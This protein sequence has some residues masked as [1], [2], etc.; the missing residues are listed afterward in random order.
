MKKGL[1]EI[2]FIADGMLGKLSRWLRILGYDVKYMENESDNKLIEL[3]EK[4][5]RILL[6]SDLQL[7]TKALKSG[8]EAFLVD[9]KNDAANLAKISEKFNLRLELD[10]QTSR[11][12]ICNSPLRMIPPS[13]VE[14]KVPY[15]TLRTYEEFWSCTNV[16]CQ[17]IYWQGSHWKNIKEKL[18]EAK[19]YSG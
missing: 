12:P 14:G 3:A 16:D 13:E 5:R 18:K 1:G 8:V 15:S 19:K 17:K 11:C 10:I 7:L 4:D 6:T 9:G 2:R